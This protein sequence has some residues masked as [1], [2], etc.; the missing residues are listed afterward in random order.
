MHKKLWLKSFES[1]MIVLYRQDER[2]RVLGAV[3]T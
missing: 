3:L 1:Q 2:R